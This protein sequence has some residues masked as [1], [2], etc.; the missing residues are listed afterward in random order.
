MRNDPPRKGYLTLL[1]YETHLGRR[2]RRRERHA[3]MLFW[4]TLLGAALA[5]V[6]IFAQGSLPI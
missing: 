3:N 2:R 5:A 1:S 6:M 4:L